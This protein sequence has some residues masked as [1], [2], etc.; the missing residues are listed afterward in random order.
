MGGGT[1]AALCS[2]HLAGMLCSLQSAAFYH[3][4]RITT[5]PSEKNAAKEPKLSGRQLVFLVQSMTSNVE[6]SSQ[7]TAS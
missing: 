5:G 1:N 6:S 2:A 7:G 3:R 4:G